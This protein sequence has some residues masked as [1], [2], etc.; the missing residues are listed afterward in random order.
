MGIYQGGLSI[1]L[2]RPYYIDVNDGSGVTRSI[3]FT[4]QDST[5]FLTGDI[6]G[7]SGFTKG[8]N[9]LKVNPGLYVKTALR[10]DFGR[11]NESLQAIEIGIS[12]EAYSK[13]VEQLVYSNAKQLFYQGH[14]A[15]VFGRRK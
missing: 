13:K 15:F 8:F 1:G 6:I 2:M 10:F 4:P 5:L 3:K 7:S 14:I 9:E 12:L 11:Y